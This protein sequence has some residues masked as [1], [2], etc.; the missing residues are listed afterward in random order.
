[1]NSPFR[2]DPR[3]GVVSG[4]SSPSSQAQPL[5][6]RTT[7]ADSVT[8]ESVSFLWRPYLPRKFVVMDGHPGQGKSTL[9]I[10]FAART[11]TGGPWPDGSLTDPAHVLIANVEDG[12]ADTI[13]PR[14]IAANADLAMVH[15][16]DGV[17][18]DGDPEDPLPFSLA[19]SKH[20]ADKARDIGNVG[21]I[22]LDPLMAML[23]GET[24]SYK[25]SEIRSVL[26][27]WAKLA[28]DLCACVIVVR[29]LTKGSQGGP[30]LLR[31][32]GSVGVIGAARCGLAVVPAPK[33]EGEPDD[34]ARIMTVTKCNVARMPPSL[35]FRLESSQ[36][37]H[38]RIVWGGESGLSADELFANPSS[39]DV[40]DMGEVGDALR[41]LFGDRLE[42]A[43]KEADEVLRNRFGIDHNRAKAKI[44]RSLGIETKKSGFSGGWIW[45]WPT[46]TAK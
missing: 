15:L 9:T 12:A 19:F 28:D 43:S 30:A 23:P 10:E 37:E 17:A 13:V 16:V 29:H 8:P 39:D 5:R 11:T 40:D 46:G 4:Q 21:L 35:E 25:D 44:R 36:N 1:V 33:A 34:G 18:A 20:V 6:L 32:Q 41:A 27:P 31:G 24:N 14:L 3:Y 7:R 38:A 22:V 42:I 2:N 45:Y 26:R